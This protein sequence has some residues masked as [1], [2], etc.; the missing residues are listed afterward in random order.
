MMPRNFI[1][2]KTMPVILHELDKWSGKLTWNDFALKVASALGEKSVGRHSLLKYPQIVEAFNERKKTLKSIPV[3][4]PEANV[5]LEFAL[6][7]I[8]KLDAENKRLK[9]QVNLFQE[10]FVRWQNNL[11]QMPGVDMEKL[12]SQLDKPLPQVSRR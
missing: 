4:A 11:M 5:T 1:T 8:S 7:E 10:Q 12:N 9:R 3:Q 2:E 6:S